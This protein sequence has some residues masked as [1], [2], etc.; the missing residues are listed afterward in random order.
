[1]RLQQNKKAMTG[2]NSEQYYRIAARFVH[3]GEILSI[4]PY[5]D[6]LINDT[7]KVTTADGTPDYIL[8][9]INDNVFKDVAMLQDNIRKVTEHLHDRLLR[10][11]EGDLGRKVLRFADT[12]DGDNYAYDEGTASYWRMMVFIPEARTYETVTPANAYKTGLAISR[13]HSLLSDMPYGLGETIPHFHDM[14]FRLEEFRQAV[15]CDKASRASSVA[16]LIS[17]IEERAED[18]TAAERLYSEGRLPKRI[19]H[20]D[21]K[22]NNLLFDDN[23]EVLA[24]IDL[25]T[26]MPSFIFSDYGDFLRNAAN[27]TAEDDP[28]MA[29][30]GFNPEIFQSFTKGYLQGAKAFITPAETL[31][32]PF[33]VKLFPYMQCVR[34]L[35][36]YLNGDTYYKTKYPEHNLV[37]ARNQFAL[38]KSIEDYD[39]DG[40][41]TSFIAQHL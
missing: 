21:T 9:R 35:G 17:E 30:V 26:V 18:M 6:G 19:C 22:V 29:K 34:F 41:M 16:G 27:F 20:C 39:R 15:A 1:M 3:E 10:E 33:A 36:D 38:L 31:M 25:D 7:F 14:A 37:R 4:M 8:Q 12:P 11:G 2:S 5:G 28:D 24:V 40:A 13:F 23:G 32:L